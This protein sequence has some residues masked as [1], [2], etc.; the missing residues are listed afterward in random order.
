MPH[1]P[2]IER[3]IEIVQVFNKDHWHL[4]GRAIVFTVIIFK[5]VDF[6][7]LRDIPSEQNV[8]DIFIAY[9]A[10]PPLRA[11]IDK[12]DIITNDAHSYDEN[13]KK[14]RENEEPVFIYSY[15]L[16]ILPL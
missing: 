4:N 6:R 15:H 9:K 7:E 14:S 10:V 5:I 11:V 8:I 13:N 1:P 3:Q 16:D 2:S 12:F